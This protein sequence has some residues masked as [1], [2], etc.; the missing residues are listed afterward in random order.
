MFV[1]TRTVAT[2]VVAAAAVRVVKAA[3][4][5]LTLAIASTAAGRAFSRLVDTNDT[6]VEPV[7]G[8]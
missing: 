5:S 7:G 8:G 6:A 1:S 2:A 4:A 3:V